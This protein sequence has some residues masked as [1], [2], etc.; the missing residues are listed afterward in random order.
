MK[1]GIFVRKL[2]DN[3]HLEV[4]DT[5]KTLQSKGVEVSL[6]QELSELAHLKADK[7]F[8]QD[9]DIVL[10][11]GGD[12]TFLRAVQKAAPFQIPVLGINLGTL[13][14]LTEVE[15]SSLRKALDRIAMGDYTIEK[16]MMIKG[17]LIR[18][19]KEFTSVNA[20]NDIYIY[21]NLYS[22]MIDI[23]AYIDRERVAVS[24]ADGLI[25]ATP[26]GS[27]AYSLSAGG[28]VVDPECETM[29]IVM[30]C[31]HR[32]DQR[33]MVIPA[34]KTIR[35]KFNM[36]FGPSTF[37]ADGEVITQLSQND[38]LIINKSD[39]YALMV[40]FSQFEFYR[41]L[42]LKFDWGSKL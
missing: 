37:F 25:V 4:I 33:P 10:S 6:P 36:S 24:K 23:K 39:H 12:G 42:S 9:C 41:L 1:V 18:E 11:L 21:R 20:L 34:H 13:G 32:V 26:T 40:R 2:T 27:T 3:L 38:E 29:S 17:T 7:N 35:M 28:P 5:V 22:Q 19:G 30:I 14:Y 8:P 15:G 16:R 31:P